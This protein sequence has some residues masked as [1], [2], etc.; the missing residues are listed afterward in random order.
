[1]VQVEAKIYGTD[2]NGT[3]VV[4]TDGK[5]YSVQPERV[6]APAATG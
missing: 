6:Q 1:L 3:I 5:T 2:V 4:V